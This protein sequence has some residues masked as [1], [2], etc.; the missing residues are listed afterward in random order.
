[1]AILTRSRREIEE[2]IQLGAGY[3]RLELVL[4]AGA[5]AHV[6]WR[7]ST[8]NPISSKYQNQH[9]AISNQSVRSCVPK[10]LAI[11]GTHDRVLRILGKSIKFESSPAVLDVG[12]GQ[13]ALSIRLKDAGARVSACD[14]VPEQFDVPGVEFRA[15]AS[16]GLLPFD[17]A[18]FD[19]A[20]AIEVLE[21]IDGH[22]RFFAEVARVLRP[23]GIVM[24]TTPNILSLKSRMRFLFTGFFYSFG[25]LEPFTR[26]PVSQHIA[27]YS[28]NRYEWMMSQHGLRLS[29][30][31]TDRIQTSSVL[32]AFLLPLIWLATR[33]QFGGSA[34]A[35]RQNSPVALYGRKLVVI[36]K[37]T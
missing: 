9:A 1:M 31:E 11:P 25:P 13:G 4:V 12:A 17:D 7:A 34:L 5:W 16:D 18:S 6:R 19:A 21:H 35:Q 24:F 32:L 23:G 26:D 10:E 20:V 22:D 29:G 3:C 14:V 27:P 36:G 2:D 37:K 30:L 8:G 28:V 33:L 15:I